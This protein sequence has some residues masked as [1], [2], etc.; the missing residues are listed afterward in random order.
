M[1]YQEFTKFILY[2]NNRKR[3]QENKRAEGK[4]KP[5]G[6]NKFPDDYKPDY[7]PE[8]ESWLLYFNCLSSECI[9]TVS[10]LWLF[11]AVP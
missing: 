2:H 1:T 9:V 6:L 3:R 10:V 4:N 7:K 8:R 11:L 5:L